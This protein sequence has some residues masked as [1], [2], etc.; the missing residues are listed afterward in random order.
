MGLKSPSQLTSRLAFLRQPASIAVL[1]SLGIHGA[2]FGAAPSFSSLIPAGLNG[3]SGAGTEAPRTVP[4][5]ELTPEE[6][7]RLPDFSNSAYS[8]FPGSGSNSFNLLPVPGAQSPS[9]SPNGGKPS[10]LPPDP[11]AMGSNPFAIGMSPYVPPSRPSIVFP[12]RRSNLPPVARPPRSATGQPTTTRPNQPR[13]PDGAASTPGTAASTPTASTPTTRPEPGAAD[14]LPPGSHSTPAAARGGDGGD[15]AIASSG[16][17]PAA[18]QGNLR[19]QLEALAYNAAGTTAAEA[20]AA[21][22]DWMAAV[23][24]EA[25]T[26]DV[27]IAD[28]IEL[29]VSYQSRICLSP[30]PVNGVIGVWVAPDGTLGGDPTVLKS[31]GYPLLNQQ[32]ALEI[33]ALEFPEEDAPVAYEFTIKVNYDGESCVSREQILQSKGK[34]Q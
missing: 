2:L 14:L 16:S 3:G 34:A 19:D 5:L 8:L 32:A 30:E 17:T 24:E 33:A 23:Q 1:I 31:T 4:L 21:R 7:N 25:K 13:T 29:P 11:F 22:Q 27:G 15:P 28:P 9:P 6:Q 12:T 10:T 26:A 20:E 18:A